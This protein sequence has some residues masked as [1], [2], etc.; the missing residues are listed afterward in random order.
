[1]K[2]RLVAVLVDLL[3]DC[4]ILLIV[5]DDS[6]GTPVSTFPELAAALLREDE[7]FSAASSRTEVTVIERVETH[8]E[9]GQDAGIIEAVAH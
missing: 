5:R 4:F 3:L 1:M 6:P 2:A 9:E 7:H 8:R